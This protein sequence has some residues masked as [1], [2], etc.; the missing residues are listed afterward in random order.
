MHFNLGM[1]ESETELEVIVMTACMRGVAGL[2]AEFEPDAS[3]IMAKGMH[4]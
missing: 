1:N 4:M 2:S 3:S